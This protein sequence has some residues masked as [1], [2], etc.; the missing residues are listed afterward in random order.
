MSLRF[1]NHE[2][3]PCPTPSAAAPVSVLASNR[4]CNQ[5][6]VNLKAAL[7]VGLVLAGFLSGAAQAQQ[8][9]VGTW[10]LSGTVA[11][12]GQSLHPHHSTEGN[13]PRFLRVELTATI[14][15]QEGSAFYG[16][17]RGPRG[18]VDRFV[19]SIGPSGQGVVVND[20]GGQ[21]RFTVVN[22]DRLESLYSLGS[23]SYLAAAYTIW[24]R[25]PK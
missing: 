20:R 4:V 24:Q 1:S 2:I 5:R 23:K 6:E 21:Y 15:A 17:M 14:E 19:G 25:Q 7:V 11:G 22:P 13:Q 8:N 9:L 18:S 16:S 12:S 10:K 3:V